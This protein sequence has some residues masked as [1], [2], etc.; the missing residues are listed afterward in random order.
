[1]KRNIIVWSKFFSKTKT[2]LL[3]LMERETKNKIKHYHVASISSSILLAE[4]GPTL[5]E[6]KKNTGRE[7]TLFGQISTKFLII[8][9]LC[10]HS[11]S[12]THL[13]QIFWTNSFV[14][15]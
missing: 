15:H 4:R 12:R 1:M 6:L 11:P 13:L 7:T 8:P 5:A 14:L 9:L 10:R 2:G 3:G